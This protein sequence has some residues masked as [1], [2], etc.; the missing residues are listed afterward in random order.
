MLSAWS[1]VNTSNSSQNVGRLTSYT[2]RR[3]PRICRSVPVPS[4]ARER[5]SI[6]DRNRALLQYQTTLCARDSTHSTLLFTRHQKTRVRYKPTNWRP[7]EHQQ[8][9]L[10]AT[11]D[12][13]NPRRRY[14]A[15]NQARLRVTRDQQNPRQRYHARNQARLRVTRDCQERN[16][17]RHREEISGN[18]HLPPPSKCLGHPCQSPARQIDTNS[19]RAETWGPP[20]FRQLADARTLQK[21]FW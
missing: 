14:H 13:Q 21:Q 1:I 18:E 4:N 11:R 17:Q 2:C 7:H 16:F 15:R 19:C 8:P 6:S 12:Q 10:R 9:R 5:S 20:R 3:A